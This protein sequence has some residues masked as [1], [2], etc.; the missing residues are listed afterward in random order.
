[1]NEKAMP[2]KERAVAMVNKNLFNLPC[3]IWKLK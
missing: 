2:R 1:M 3:Q